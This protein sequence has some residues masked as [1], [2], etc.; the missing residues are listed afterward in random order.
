MYLVEF[1]KIARLRS[2]STVDYRTKNPITD[3]YPRS[4]Q[5]EKDALKFRK[6]QKNLGKTVPFSLTLQVDSP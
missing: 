2:T 1:D 3:N 6:F 4:S 5:K